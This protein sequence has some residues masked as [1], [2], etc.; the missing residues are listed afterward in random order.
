MK[1][2]NSNE[3]ALAFKY[4]KN[5][6]L[7]ERETLKTTPCKKKNIGTWKEYTYLQDHPS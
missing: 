1:Y 7:S 6:L 5:G 2:G 3:Y 4:F